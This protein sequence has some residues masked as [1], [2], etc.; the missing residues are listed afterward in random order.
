[1]ARVEV[2]PDDGGGTLLLLEHDLSYRQGW[3]CA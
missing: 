1:V 2:E 3:E